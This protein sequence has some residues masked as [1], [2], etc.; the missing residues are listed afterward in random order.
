[1]KRE[2]FTKTGW[3]SYKMTFCSIWRSHFSKPT[4]YIS[5]HNS[6]IFLSLSKGIQAMVVIHMKISRLFMKFYHELTP[7][8]CDTLYV[9]LQKIINQKGIIYI[10]D[11]WIIFYL[12]RI[13]LEKKYQSN[14]NKV[15][16]LSIHTIKIRL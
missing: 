14:L 13:S 4:W 2:Y 1:M 9:E 16:Y 10:Y 12:S 3:N 15:Q 5:C 7:F 6:Y 11:L 8:N